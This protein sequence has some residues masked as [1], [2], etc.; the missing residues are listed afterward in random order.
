[1]D[2]ILSNLLPENCQKRQIAWES[3]LQFV[4]QECTAL[5]TT[6]FNKNTK[7]S[8]QTIGGQVFRAKLNITET[9]Q[10]CASS[11][12]SFCELE[13]KL[14]QLRFSA[15][16]KLS[17]LIEQ[18]SLET[19]EVW[20]ELKWFDLNESICLPDFPNASL[21]MVLVFRQTVVTTR[22]RGGVPRNKGTQCASSVESCC[23]LPESMMT[24][25]GFKSRA[26]T[27][28]NTRVDAFPGSAESPYRGS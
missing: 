6:H 3:C 12:L 5:F 23:Q 13:L 28:V 4:R 2:G 26:L 18:S 16:E 14:F 1:M 22:L 11:N 27:P 19:A 24:F 7:H 9:V 10:E 21:S 15:V 8:Q 17:Y 20:C 25:Y